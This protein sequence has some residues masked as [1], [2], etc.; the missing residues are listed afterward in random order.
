MLGT[1][2]WAAHISATGF[3]KGNP[4]PQESQTL[5]DHGEST[6]AGAEVLGRVG[7]RIKWAG[8]S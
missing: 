2:G 3:Q 4:G 8:G 5:T 6:V 7:E 1:K